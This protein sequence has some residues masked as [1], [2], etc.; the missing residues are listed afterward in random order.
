MPRKE[1]I[2]RAN[3]KALICEQAKDAGSHLVFPEK[4]VPRKPGLPSGLT[5]AEYVHLI[6][7]LGIL[8]RR[9]I[10]QVMHIKP[11][12]VSQHRWNA[13]QKLGPEQAAQWKTICKVFKAQNIFQLPAPGSPPARD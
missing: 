9:Q 10:G 6:L 8:N 3:L 1:R 11:A 5:V 12:S 4:I 13:Y 2:A 7:D